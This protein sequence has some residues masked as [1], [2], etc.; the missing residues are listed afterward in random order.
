MGPIDQLTYAALGAGINPGTTQ[1]VDPQ[2]IKDYMD[3]NP[4]VNRA[5]AEQRVRE[6]L[7]GQ[8]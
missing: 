5:D 4:N 7:A 8:G 6:L 2:L 1:E 3:A